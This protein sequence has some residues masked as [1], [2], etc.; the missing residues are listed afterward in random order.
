MAP[1]PDATGATQMAPTPRQRPVPASPHAGRNFCDRVAALGGLGV[2][3]FALAHWI[4]VPGLAATTRLGVAQGDRMVIAAWLVCGLMMLVGGTVRL[5]TMT[6]FGADMLLML[7]A[8]GAGLLMLSSTSHWPVVPYAALA[9]TGLV[10]SLFA[11]IIDRSETR[12]EL[13]VARLAGM[14]S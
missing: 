5:R 9:L 11:R 1:L 13:L 2:S 10:V 7:S 4:G 14:A 6:M 12:R 3:V 8:L